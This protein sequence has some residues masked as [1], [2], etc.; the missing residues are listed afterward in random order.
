MSPASFDDLDPNEVTT[1]EE[2]ALLLRRLH[3][4]AGRPSLR[5]LEKWAQEQRAAG[6]REVYLSRSSVSDALN[7]K[8]LPS[9]E[10]VRW[11]VEACAVPLE[12]RGGWL[13]AWERVADYHH[14]LNRPMD[15]ARGVGRDMSAAP[16]TPTSTAEVQRPG[17]L[18]HAMPELNDQAVPR[19][20]VAPILGPVKGIQP[21]FVDLIVVTAFM[22]GRAVNCRVTE[23]LITA[24]EDGVAYYT[25]RGFVGTDSRPSFSPVQAL[26]G[27]TAELLDPSHPAWPATRLRFPTP[28]RSGES[29]YF[30]SQVTNEDVG[31]ERNWI[32]VYAD[33]HG[34]APG[35][36]AYG[37]RLPVS[38]L[39]IRVRF[40]EGCLP[41]AVWWYAERSQGRYRRPSD[42]DRHL[43]AVTGRDV[44]YT[45]TDG[46]CRS[47]EN[48][49][50]AF[51]WPPA[52]T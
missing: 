24:L 32:D 20:E 35:R 1:M 3:V 52:E 11:F 12:K 10:F 2:F 15:P 31:N 36:L 44:Q 27:C 23:R 43:L 42:G 41:E 50:I 25:A 51:D 22:R 26:W 6:R 29:T 16:L 19:G 14:V 37:N 13:K 40:D 33:H 28:L 47:G 39:T 49:G 46:S 38:G 7:G 21:V 34:I 5:E 4:R 48:Y 9:K 17:S 45:F 18:R 30:A 8:R